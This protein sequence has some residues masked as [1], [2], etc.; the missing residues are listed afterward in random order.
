LIA[1]QQPAASASKNL[2]AEV[3]FHLRNRQKQGRR[4]IH[5]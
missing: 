3:R 1:T 5:G 2:L 4:D